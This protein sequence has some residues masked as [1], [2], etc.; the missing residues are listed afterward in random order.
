MNQTD[1]L[2]E[3]RNI[4]G[5]VDCARGALVSQVPSTEE[6]SKSTAKKRQCDRSHRSKEREHA[7]LEHQP[8]GEG[9]NLKWSRRLYGPCL[10]KDL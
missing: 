2:L 8:S 4:I 5:S 1:T 9:D 6:P 3:S 10:K 7:P